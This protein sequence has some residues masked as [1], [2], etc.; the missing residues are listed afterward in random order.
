MAAAP[1]VTPVP[2]AEPLDE[3]SLALLVRRAPNT[4]LYAQHAQSIT[5]TVFFQ[6]ALCCLRERQ[7]KPE[8]LYHY[9]VVVPP[10]GRLTDNAKARQCAE[11]GGC[12][13][14]PVYE[15]EP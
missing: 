15:E 11:C 2:T 13:D 8:S 9:T 5:G 4:P 1:H 6:H 3:L 10:R 14:S 7:C 12:V